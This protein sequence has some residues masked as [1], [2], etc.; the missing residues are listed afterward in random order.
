MKNVFGMKFTVALLFGLLAISR[1]SAQDASAQNKDLKKL[2]ESLEYNTIAFDD[3]K[4]NWI[5]NDPLFI[6]EIYNR[7]VV[8][9][10]LRENGKS[11][12][13]EELKIKSQDIYD[14]KLVVELRKR[15]YDEE[16]EFFAFVPESEVEKKDPKY[17]FDPI[18]DPFYLKDILGE[19]LYFKIRTQSYYFSNL[20][21]TEFDTKSGYYFLANLNM[22]E[23]EVMYWSTTSNFRNKYLLSAFGKWGDERIGL[24]GWY[25]KEYVFGTQLTYFNKISSNPDNYTY[26]IKV[27]T[28]LSAGTPFTGDQQGK[29]PLFTTGQSLYLKITGNPMVF[30]DDSWQDF[31]MSLELKYTANEYKRKEFGLRDTTEFYSNRTYFILDAR[32]KN[33]YNLFDF[34]QVEIGGGIAS[35]DLWHYKVTPNDT[36]LIDLESKKDFLQKFRPFVYFDAGISRTGGLIQHKIQTFFAADVDMGAFLVG[37]KS[38]V[39]LSDNFGFDVR[40]I[41]SFGVSKSKLPKWANDSFIVFSPIFKINY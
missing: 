17:A 28:A 37:L 11:L 15:Y 8:K 19:R 24:P 13:V 12:T 4:Q 25:S 35:M 38:Q 34:G 18:K 33:L 22:L 9:D 16:I 29:L 7:F 27:G 40:L 23:P 36:K 20:T 5:I 2:Y 14:G 3:L 6:R 31:R 1:V 30:F 39:T 41:N 32:Q 21:K 10:A 26:Q